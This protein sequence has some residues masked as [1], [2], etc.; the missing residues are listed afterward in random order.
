MIPSSTGIDGFLHFHRGHGLA[1]GIMY[2]IVCQYGYLVIVM[3]PVADLN[4]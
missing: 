3:K 2:R 1:D 4:K